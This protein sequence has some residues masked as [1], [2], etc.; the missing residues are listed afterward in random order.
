MY[1]LVDL[2]LE[3]KRSKKIILTLDIIAIVFLILSFT[4]EGMKKLFSIDI[5]TIPSEVVT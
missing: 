3:L 1:S 4:T 5:L 2:S